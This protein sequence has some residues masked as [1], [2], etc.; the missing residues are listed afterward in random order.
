MESA[1]LNNRGFSRD[2]TRSRVCLVTPL[3]RHGGQAFGVVYAVC[4]LQCAVSAL[5]CAVS[6]LQCAVSA[7]QCA[8]SAL[9]CAVSALQCA[10][11]ALQCA[12]SALQCAVYISSY[13]PACGLV[14]LL[15]T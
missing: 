2:V 1:H 15:M 3:I 13:Q 10:V 8:V 11:S 6:A 14:C 12:V 9:Q 5:Q 4:A 7:L